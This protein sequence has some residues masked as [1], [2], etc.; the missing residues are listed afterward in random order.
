M[1]DPNWMKNCDNAV[2]E[3]TMPQRERDYSCFFDCN[4]LKIRHASALLFEKYKLI[5]DCEINL[6][7]W[8]TSILSWTSLAD[9]WSPESL[10]VMMNLSDWTAARRGWLTA[11]SEAGQRDSKIW[12]RTHPKTEA[13][14]FSPHT[15]ALSHAKLWW[16]EST[17]KMRNWADT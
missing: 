1:A 15:C 16:W 5:N 4:I 3:C 2:V 10:W 11:R 13:P 14:S 17:N 6:K 8:T 12:S 7:S 9:L